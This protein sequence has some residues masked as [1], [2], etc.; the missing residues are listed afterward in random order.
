LKCG[1]VS[2]Q[3]SEKATYKSTYHSPADSLVHLLNHAFA[4]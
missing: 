3:S 2:L 4:Q 1:S